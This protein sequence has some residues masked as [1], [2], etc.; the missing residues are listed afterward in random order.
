MDNANQNMEANREQARNA[1][2]NRR[3]RR[4]DGEIREL[5]WKLIDLKRKLIEQRSQKKE[6]SILDMKV[7]L[8]SLDK[9]PTV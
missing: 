4:Q 5:K 6:N 3:N 2:V 9:N 1:R 7:P 8:L